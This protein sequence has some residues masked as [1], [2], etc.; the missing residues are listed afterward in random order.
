M[1]DSAM[2]LKQHRVDLACCPQ[3]EEVVLTA[4]SNISDRSNLSFTSGEWVAPDLHAFYAAIALLSDRAR[5]SAGN[6][7][8]LAGDSKSSNKASCGVDELLL[9]QEVSKRGPKALGS[10]TGAGVKQHLGPQCY[11]LLPR[12]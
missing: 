11:C 1:I 5:F 12:V 3:E 6:P 2:I 4:D 9:E 10:F 8:G 7:P